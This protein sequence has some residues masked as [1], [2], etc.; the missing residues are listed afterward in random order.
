MKSFNARKQSKLTEGGSPWS[1]TR[2]ILA[3]TAVAGLAVGGLIAPGVAGASTST[4]AKAKVVVSGKTYKF[5]GGGCLVTSSR[6]AL[7]IG[8]GGNT[9]GMNA[10]VKQGKFSNAQIGMVLGGKPVAVTSASGT[11][12]GTGGTFKGTDVVSNSSVSGTFNC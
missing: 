2:R 10:K 7:G 3:S 8:S 1:T 4:N 9:F 12:K 5:S 11:T 6:I